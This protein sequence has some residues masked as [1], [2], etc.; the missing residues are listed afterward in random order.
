MGLP[1]YQPTYL[2]GDAHRGICAAKETFWPE[3]KR[4]QCYYHMKMAVHKQRGKLPCPATDWK[5]VKWQIEQLHHAPTHAIFNA[6][7]ARLVEE[8]YGKGWDDFAKYFHDSWLE[9]TPNW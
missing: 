2:M 1:K 3:T 6:A 9:G 8:W 4:L 7:S 5:V